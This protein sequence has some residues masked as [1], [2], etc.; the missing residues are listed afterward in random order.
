LRI[1]S[2]K[3]QKKKKTILLRGRGKK[4]HNNFIQDFFFRFEEWIQKTNMFTCYTSNFS[5]DRQKRYRK[6]VPNGSLPPQRGVVVGGNQK[7]AASGAKGLHSRCLR[8]D[9]ISLSKTFGITITNK[10]LKKIKV[11]IRMQYDLR[12][13]LDYLV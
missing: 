2:G 6:I 4:R 8:K 11:S 5:A 1:F 10:N 13:Q 3:T 12:F 9:F 7:T